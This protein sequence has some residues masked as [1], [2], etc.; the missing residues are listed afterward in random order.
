MYPTLNE[1]F[2]Y[3]PLEAMKYGTLCACSANSATTEVCADAVLY[4]NPYDETEI[5]I[6]IL[7]SFDKDIC[8]EKIEKMRVRYDQ[9]RQKQ[10]HDLDVLV[11]LI[12]SH[13]G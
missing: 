13:H 8:E 12:A 6:R 9:V 10:N 3:P 1:G 7:Q 11:N 2:G 4:F 5:G